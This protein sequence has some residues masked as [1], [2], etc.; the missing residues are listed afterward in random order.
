MLRKTISVLLALAMVLSLIHIFYFLMQTIVVL[1]HFLP[2]T[3]Y[4]LMQIIV[5]LL[6][7]LP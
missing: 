5:V 7:F 4:F 1:L 6:H 2:Q 3:I